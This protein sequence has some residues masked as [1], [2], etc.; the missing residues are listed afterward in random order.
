[1]TI[2]GQTTLDFLG[3]FIIVLRMA[4]G[5]VRPSKSVAAQ[6]PVLEASCSVRGLDP[7]A[8]QVPHERHVNGTG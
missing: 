7:Q 2:N 8:E 5:R 3:V 4:S 6:D 1:M